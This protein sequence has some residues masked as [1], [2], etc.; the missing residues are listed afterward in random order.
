M[1]KANSLS[2]ARLWFV[3]PLLLVT[4]GA[5]AQDKAQRDAL[6][7]L[8]EFAER[9]CATAPMSSKSE[10][11]EVSGQVKVDL[12]Q[13]LAKI[14]GLGI[15]GAAKYQDVETQGVLQKDLAGLI[16]NSNDCKLKVVLSLQEKLIPAA[17]PKPVGLGA[18]ATGSKPS[19]SFRQERAANGSW[20]WNCDGNVEKQYQSCESMAPKACTPNTNATGSPPGF[21]STLR[22]PDGCKAPPAQ[23]GSTGYIYPCFYHA[24][25]GRCHAG[26]YETE[27]KLGCR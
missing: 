16:V 11:L 18:C 17:A 22:A 2:A 25:D 13:V 6:M 1:R 3:L 21:C 26:G 23:C 15:S 19:N 12:N 27:A 8:Q 9:I 7:M 4:S 14:A 10:A 20:D 24:A 5:H